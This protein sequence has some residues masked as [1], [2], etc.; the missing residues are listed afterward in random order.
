MC[1]AIYTLNKYIFKI[2]KSDKTLKGR[3]TNKGKA[4]KVFEKIQIFHKNCK[5]IMAA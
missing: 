1:Q 3:E 5:F 2:V 4:I